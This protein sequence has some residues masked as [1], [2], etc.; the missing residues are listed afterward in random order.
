MP[1]PVIFV[2]VLLVVPALGTLSLQQRYRVLPEDL[3]VPFAILEAIVV[4]VYVYEVMRPNELF[5]TIAV[6]LF[7]GSG[8]SVTVAGLIFLIQKMLDPHGLDGRRLLLSAIYLWISN[9]LM[10]AVA[11]WSIDAGGPVARHMGARARDLVFPEM[12]LDDGDKT[13]FRPKFGD[14][15]YVAFST[16]TAFSATDTLTASTR[17]RALIMI[18]SAISLATLAIVAARA[19]NIIPAG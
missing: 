13:P 10:F 17:I 1:W 9:V 16:S 15:M 4:V 12:T 11:Y 5:A 18:Q 8:L 19:V 7:C 6:W 2:Y 3:A 14:Y